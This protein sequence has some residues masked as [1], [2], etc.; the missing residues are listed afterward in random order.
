MSFLRPLLYLWA[1]PNTF[2]GLLVVPLAI[3][4][5]GGVRVVDGVLE[6][7][8]P[9]VAMLLQHCTVLPGGAIAMTLGH[10]VLARDHRT[11]E[12]T[13]AHERAHVHQAE[14]WGPLFIPAYL[15][16]SLWAMLHKRH[17]YRDNVFEI[18]AMRRETEAARR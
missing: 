1:F 16:A 7:H 2:L 11:L 6:I 13:R 12:A 3:I 10:T 15:G 8:G 17:F 14:R 4:T 5:R 18:D 9:G